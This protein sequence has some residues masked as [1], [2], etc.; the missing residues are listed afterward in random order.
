MADEGNESE[1]SAKAQPQ[2]GLLK[3]RIAKKAYVF[4]V[5]RKY[6]ATRAFSLKKPPETPAE[7]IKEGILAL[8]PK[9]KPKGEKGEGQPKHQEVQPATPA[10]K[11]PFGLA[12]KIGA[13]IILLFILA[14]AYIVVQYSSAPPQA[15]PQA[16]FGAFGGKYTYDVEKSFIVS[17]GEDDKGQDLRVAYFL[18]RSSGKNLTELNLT[19]GL[20]SQKPP[21][22]VFVLD[23]VRE[24]AY[25]Y[26]L[27]RSKLSQ[28]LKRQGMSVND[29]DPSSLRLLPGGCI[30]VIPTGYFPAGLINGE[31]GVTYKELLSRGVDIAYIGYPFSTT[32]LDSTGS[33]VSVNDPEFKFTESRPGSAGGFQLFDAQYTVDGAGTLYGSVSYTNRGQGTMMFIPQTLDGGWQND[34]VSDSAT[35]A[36]SDISMLLSEQPWI[37]PFAT[38]ASPAFVDPDGNFTESSLFTSAFGSEAA[39]AKLSLLATDLNGARQ[40]T[41]E[42]YPVEKAQKGEMYV[43]DASVVPYFLSSQKTRLNLKL[44]EN[45][46][47][48]VK[49]YVVMYKE[50]EELQR[51]ELEVG[52]TNPTIDK[53]V[54]FQ[55]TAPPGNYVVLAV[56]NSGK[57][58]AATKLDVTDLDIRANSTDWQAGRFGFILSAGGKPI[59]PRSVT[60]FFDGQGARAY[61]PSDLR[62]IDGGTYLEYS[63]YG[64]MDPG[65][66]IFT[67]SSGEWAKNVYLNYYRT[68]NFWE[69]PLVIFLAVVSAIIFGIGY[70]IRRP[71]ALNYG[72]DIPDFPPTMTVKIPV[73]SET[74]LEI[75][76]S[77]N[78]S[79]SWKWMPLRL[80]EVKNGFRKLTYNGKPIIVGDYNLERILARLKE[81]GLVASELDY[82]GLMEWEKESKHSI[83]YLTL[84]RIM[85]NIFV[86]NAVKFSR[87]DAMPD[88]DVKAIVDKEE[89]YFHI[90]EPPESRV[91]HRAL[92]TAK[93]GTTIIVFRNDEELESFSSSLVSTS[94]LAVALKMEVM[95]SN[96]RL[97]PVKIAIAAFLKQKLG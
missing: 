70:V 11:S 55:V 9:K 34:E 18:I 3:L 93:Q 53:S 5:K 54:D 65:D 32:A 31:W 97:M 16:S 33:T 68:R 1:G 19:V 40:K 67:F 52:L 41:I 96:I 94:K 10:A 74:V 36:A 29:I 26:P 66:H 56:D 21:V 39:V 8:M 38:A 4:D 81:Q 79:Y 71:E 59:N 2:S 30:L 27:F 95:G 64:K 77:V 75:F 84:Y 44:R 17:A 92:A 20:F 14:I 58:Y 88:C 13:G 25:T 12:L 28:N 47:T 6:T 78:A 37:S 73:K 90:M 72:L 80:D 49:L 50:G 15:P 23:H 51:S 42:M 82:W 22:Q 60:V 63:Y 76:N 85:R 57:A 91:V 7:G 86:N 83:R 46:S 62:R 45:S 48:P 61:S 43:R 24:G 87:I 35:K 69:D 89:L